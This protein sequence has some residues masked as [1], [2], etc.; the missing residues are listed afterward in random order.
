MS[1]VTA[2]R[3]PR[4]SHRRSET[5]S[6]RVPGRL[7]SPKGDPLRAAGFV[8]DFLVSVSDTV[9]GELAL[10]TGAVQL[11]ATN[12]LERI[13]ASP[14]LCNAGYVLRDREHKHATVIHRDRDWTGWTFDAPINA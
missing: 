6:S 12:R 7:R 14:S 3:E 4:W 13:T 1:F 2:K 9:H 8:L 5:R 11:V 10:E